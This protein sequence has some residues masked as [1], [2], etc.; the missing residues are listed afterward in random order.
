MGSYVA[1]YGG[2]DDH[3]GVQRRRGAHTGATCLEGIGWDVRVIGLIRGPLEGPI[4]R[5]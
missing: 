4:R 1:L 2:D 5:A 3:V